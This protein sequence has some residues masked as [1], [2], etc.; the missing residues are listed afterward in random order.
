MIKNADRQE[1]NVKLVDWYTD[2][3]KEAIEAAK[4]KG[5]TVEYKV[6]SGLIFGNSIKKMLRFQ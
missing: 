1:Y 6:M 5:I 4:S 2:L 3:Y